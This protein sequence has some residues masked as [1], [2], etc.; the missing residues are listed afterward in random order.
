MSPKPKP[1]PIREKAARKQRL[2]V[3]D[4]AFELHEALIVLAKEYDEIPESLD[5]AEI[6]SF[7]T[8]LEELYSAEEEASA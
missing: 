5:G 1:V 3:R 2:L 7:V 4:A 8:K 6:I